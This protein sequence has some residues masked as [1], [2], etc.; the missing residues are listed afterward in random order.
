MGRITPLPTLLLLSLDL[1][2]PDVDVD[3]DSNNVEG[4]EFNFNDDERCEC[5]SELSSQSADID[6]PLPRFT[7]MD[8][9]GLSTHAHPWL[10]SH[11]T[12]HQIL[13]TSSRPSQ[14]RAI[15]FRIFLT[16]W[17]PTRGILCLLPVSW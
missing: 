9:Q 5:L 2:E 10:A 17:R 11:Q 7:T 6:L 12:H 13:D 1:P 4:L 15:T 14:T 3:A 16:H 8:P